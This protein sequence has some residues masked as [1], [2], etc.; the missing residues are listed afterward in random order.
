MRFPF[1][2]WLNIL[3]DNLPMMRPGYYLVA[4]PSHLCFL[5]AGYRGTVMVLADMKISSFDQGFRDLWT[6]LRKEGTYFGQEITVLLAEPATYTILREAGSVTMEQL[7]TECQLLA[8]A[9]PARQEVRLIS[10]HGVNYYAIF[11]ADGAFVEGVIARLNEAGVMIRQILTL[12]GLILGGS[13]I[14]RGKRS[15]VIQETMIGSLRCLLGRDNQGRLFYYESGAYADTADWTETVMRLRAMTEPDDS[16]LSMNGPESSQSTPEGN[17]FA[18]PCHVPRDFSRRRRQ[19]EVFGEAI[20]QKARHLLT[21]AGSARLLLAVAVAILAMTLLSGGVFSILAGNS[22]PTF[23]GYQEQV[24]SIAVMEQELR[25]V[26]RKLT[27]AGGMYGASPLF[28][29]G[30]SLFCQEIPTNLY[31]T[32]MK[33]ELLPDS[34]MRLIAQG[35]SKSEAA[36]FQYRSDLIAIDS[37]VACEIR[38]IARSG[39][40]EMADSSWYKFTLSIIR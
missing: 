28:S 22:R 18:E 39:N 20:P 7:R 17:A 29:A 34:G 1:R 23:D 40:T 14:S 19:L 35:L 8:G 25:A 33:A 24:S 26:E 37:S 9:D 31:L 10:I 15:P 16:D 32:G 11:G 30:V 3:Q 5:M 21:I 36:V 6:I 38:S 13:S 2:R 12:L 4:G 27:A